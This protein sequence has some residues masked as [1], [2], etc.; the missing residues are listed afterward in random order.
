[1]VSSDALTARGNDLVEY[2]K[3]IDPADIPWLVCF[4]LLFTA[5]IGVANGDANQYVYLLPGLQAANPDFL[6]TDWFVTQVQHP[7]RSFDKLVAVLARA[8]FLETGLAILTA[9]QSAILAMAVWLLARRLYDEPLLPWGLTLMV[10]AA[11]GTRGVGLMLLTAPQLEGSTIAGVATVTALAFMAEERNAVFAGCAF[12]IAALFHANFAILLVPV[13][14][15]GAL[16]LARRRGPLP[17]L[18]LL[19]PLL[20]FGAPSFI[21]VL[22][23]GGDPARDAAVSIMVR[24]FPHHM[25]PRSWSAAQGLMLAG[26]FLAGAAGFRLRPPRPKTVLFASV[27]VMTLLVVGSLI[28]GYAGL[29]QAIMMIAPWRLASIVILLA[30]LA[31]G[32]AAIR[33]PRLHGRLRYLAVTGLGAVAA[34]AVAAVVYGAVPARAGV[35]IAVAT[36][37]ALHSLLIRG[38]SR[39]GSTSSSE[40]D[41]GIVFVLL[42]I[43]FA[44][45][46]WHGIERSHLDIRADDE[47]RAGLYEWIRTNTPTT[48]HFAVPPGWSDFRLVARRPVV[49]AHK[50]PPMEPA[51]LIAWTERIEALTGLRPGGEAAPLDSAFLAADCRRVADIVRTYDVPYVIRASGSPPCGHVAYSGVEFMVVD[52]FPTSTSTEPADA[53]ESRAP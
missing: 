30:V 49:A 12:G 34:S 38:R 35:A 28:I 50:S 11:T 42:A 40:T 5:A 21:Q 14:A 27:A 44:P 25:D 39:C 24:R 23:H 45:S 32:A 1:M 47:A 31:A 20:V 8:G 3:P 26:V 4:T 15:V 53:P 18:G 29:S 10:L 41:R 48:A 17:A 13:V 33:P 46:V 16:V 36:V 22:Q 19:I 37:L 6:G 2:A 43:G 52:P 7:H 51:A 9:A